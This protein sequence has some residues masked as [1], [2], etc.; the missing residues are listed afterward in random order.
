MSYFID[1]FK[2]KVPIWKK[3]IYED[4]SK[5]LWNKF[6]YIKTINKEKVKNEN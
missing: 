4:S 6:L 2:E 5:W 1:Q 3:E